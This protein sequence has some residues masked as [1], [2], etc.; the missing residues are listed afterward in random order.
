MQATADSTS[1][2][3]LRG[4]RVLV[5]EDESEIRLAL[6]RRLTA[7]GYDV[8]TASDGESAPQAAIEGQPDLVLLDI[9]LPGDDG[10][11]VA[12]RLRSNPRTSDIPIVFLT[13]RS[14]DLQIA[15]QVKPAGYVIKPYRAEE[16][17]EV[18]SRVLQQ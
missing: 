18:V 13:A 10:Y 7:A 3:N 1:R 5:V 8:L 16:L 14:G 12:K 9:G 11:S 4:R 6:T 15:Q 2:D 17:L